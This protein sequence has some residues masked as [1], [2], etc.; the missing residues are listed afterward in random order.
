MSVSLLP[1]TPVIPDFPAAFKRPSRYRRGRSA[2]EE[3]RCTLSEPAFGSSTCHHRCLK[4]GT[5][6]VVTCFALIRTSRELLRASYGNCCNSFV[7]QS[8][9]SFSSPFDSQVCFCFSFL[10][11]DSGCRDCRVVRMHNS[12]SFSIQTTRIS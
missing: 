12:R 11:P 10:L 5:P 4:A 8:P 7:G 2:C 6:C 3:T 1:T 9:R